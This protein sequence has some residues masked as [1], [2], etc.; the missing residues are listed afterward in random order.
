M[1]L[2]VL[3]LLSIFVILAFVVA[4]PVYA[5]TNPDIIDWGTGTYVTYKVFYNVLENDDW[6]VVAEG[7]VYYALEPTDYTASEAFNF[8]LLDATG[9]ITLASTTLNSY[10]DRPI[11]IYLSASQRAALGLTIGTAYGIRISGNPLIFG[12]PTGNTIT[13]YLSSGDYSDQDLGDDGGIAT[14]NNLRNFLIGTNDS[15]ANHI[16]TEDAPPVGFEYIITVQGVKY[17]TNTGGNIFIEGIPNLSAMC[18]ILFQNSLAPMQ[19]DLPTSTNGTYA[20]MLNPLSKW[21]TTTANGL[22]MLGS[23]LGINQALAGSAV[24]FLLVMALSFWVYKRT[25][26]GIAVTLLVSATPFLGAWLGLM[27]MALAFIFTIIIVVLMAYFFYSRGA[28]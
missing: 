26:S 1:K 18:P 5:I 12:S 22:T 7:Y 3:K 13:A 24:L 19:G 11:S 2:K 28:L 21:G 23:F 8:E 14:N 27:P 9:N 10:G 4:T 15:M 6:L 16:Q 25:E 17:L 20:G